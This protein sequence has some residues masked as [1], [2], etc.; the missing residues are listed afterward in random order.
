MRHELE[1]T[2]W[3]LG[4]DERLL[5]FIGGGGKTSAIRQVAEECL[6][7][8]RKMLVATSTKVLMREFADYQP[9][10]VGDELGAKDVEALS[11]IWSE[12]GIPVLYRET[13]LEK[14]K[15]IGHEPDLLESMRNM[16]EELFGEPVVLLV[17]ADG[18]R[19]LPLKAPYPHEPVISKTGNVVVLIG[20][21]ILGE[22][23]KEDNVYGYDNLLD[24]L[25]RD[26]SF[27]LRPED[28]TE[29]VLH[30]A[31]YMKNVEHKDRLRVIFNK[32]EPKEKRQ[33]AL[34]TGRLLAESGVRSKVVSLQQQADYGVKLVTLILAAGMSSRMGRDKQTIPCGDM[35][36]LEKTVSLYRG[37]GEVLV[38]LGHN[39]DEILS[40]S[41]L[42][43]ARIIE[44]PDYLKGM[45]TSLSV[46]IRALRE[47][48]LDG[49]WLTFCDM[50]HLKPETL[51]ELH[52]CLS[53]NPDKIIL[54]GYEGERGH[55]AYLPAELFSEL[56]EVK[57]DMGA[58]TVVQDHEDRLLICPVKDRAILEDLDHEEILE[59][60][61]E[62]EGWK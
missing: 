53:A 18:A 39:K 44:N 13:W 57:G 11:Y 46:G 1:L 33:L 19:N 32:A 30:T 20:S 41:S 54:P 5:Y 34:E 37:F 7:R 9:L 58:R 35:N 40:E 62:R 21:E 14:K 52:E 4:E 60:V 26:G 8:G 3:L 29:L 17:E 23:I 49:V 22:M 47:Q 56:V 48:E 2:D 43:N 31:G 42:G 59:Q 24:A 50:P 36:F 6:A 16:L 45:G 10:Q 28:M 38:V 61:E 55:P 12:G 51:G 15:Y 27:Q 25:K